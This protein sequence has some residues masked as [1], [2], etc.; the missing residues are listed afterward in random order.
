MHYLISTRAHEYY[1]SIHPTMQSVGGMN[2]MLLFV[3]L[4]FPTYHSLWLNQYGSN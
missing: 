1:G 2:E 4:H 3:H